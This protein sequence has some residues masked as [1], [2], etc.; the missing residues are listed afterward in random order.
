MGIDGRDRGGVFVEREFELPVGG[1][2][3]VT[4]AP[5]F[6]LSRWLGSSDSNLFD[7]AN[8]GVVARVDGSLGPRTSA[9]G[10]VSLPASI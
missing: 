9:R 2:W 7:P 8:F 10:F 6:Y 4:V 3:Q 5:Q 1:T